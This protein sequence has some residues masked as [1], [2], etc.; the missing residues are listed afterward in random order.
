MIRS[1]LVLL[2]GLSAGLAVALPAAAADP[3]VRVS[4]QAV[5][6]YDLDLRKTADVTVLLGRIRS[7]AHQVCGAEGYGRIG[8]LSAC[9][10]AATAEAVARINQPALTALYR[11]EAPPVAV[12]QRGVTR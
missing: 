11:R 3:S 6:V 7:T 1:T 12:A 9:L 2:A 4:S 8:D 5:P 10:N